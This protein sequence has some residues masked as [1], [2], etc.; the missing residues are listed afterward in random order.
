MTQ[1]VL[2]VAPPRPLGGVPFSWST[3]SKCRTQ[4][5]KV[6]GSHCCCPRLLSL[7]W[8]N[9]K[10]RRDSDTVCGAPAGTATFGNPGT[11]CDDSSYR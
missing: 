1:P 4:P 2:R 3:S 10:A 5:A 8:M 7:P 9:G 11:L 6:S